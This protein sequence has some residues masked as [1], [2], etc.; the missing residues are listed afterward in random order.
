MFVKI[1]K[2]GNPQGALD[3]VS[4]FECKHVSK[5]TVT[6]D[7]E[8]ETTTDIVSI[9]GC[10]ESIDLAV[11]FDKN[12]KVLNYHSLNC[13]PITAGEGNLEIYCMSNEG[14]TVDKLV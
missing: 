1:V 11:D 12:G 14:K 5:E 10:T 3:G 6:L 4:I 9:T 7:E 2:K 13:G 8:K